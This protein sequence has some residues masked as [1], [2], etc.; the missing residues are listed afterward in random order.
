[1]RSTGS[2]QF[3]DSNILRSH[4][5]ED[6]LNHLSEEIHDG[7]E[8]LV[9]LK[10]AESRF[11]KFELKNDLITWKL[12]VDR[13]YLWENCSSIYN[14]LG[15]TRYGSLPHEKA[16][17]SGAIRRATA[18]VE[19]T[20]I[21]YRLNMIKY[22][23]AQGPSSGRGIFDES[24]QPVG[25]ALADFDTHRTKLLPLHKLVQ[26][27]QA[28]LEPD[29]EK[30]FELGYE[31]YKAYCFS[32]MTRKLGGSFGTQKAVMDNPYRLG[33]M[34]EERQEP[35]TEPPYPF[36]GNSEPQ[37]VPDEDLAERP[38]ERHV[39]ILLPQFSTE[40]LPVGVLPRLNWLFFD[41]G[42]S[43]PAEQS[44][45]NQTGDTLHQGSA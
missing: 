41:S 5:I 3:P 34:P 23:S 30:F 36:Q 38:I 21:N 40:S 13:I 42:N 29:W 24:G 15:N 9:R 22:L 26:S 2:S 7:K 28:P 43:I 19:L 12:D 1:M 18:V 39:S 27:E 37:W 8:F 45:Q 35:S 31:E 16:S 32:K 20:G 17:I 25:F 14:L 44:L 10:D 33:R 6:F 11:G 4:T